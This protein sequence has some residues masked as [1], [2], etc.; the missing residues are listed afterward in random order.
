MTVIEDN[1][2][3]YEIVDGDTLK[4]GSEEYT[5]NIISKDK[6]SSS[7]SIVG[8]IVYLHITSRLPEEQQKKHIATLLS[9]SIAQKRIPKIHK[10]CSILWN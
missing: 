2:L 8:N 5:L 9:R 7:A 10:F 1:G 4:I 3:V 6:D